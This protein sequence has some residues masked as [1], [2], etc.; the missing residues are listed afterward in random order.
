MKSLLKKLLNKDSNEVKG[1]V[2]SEELKP[3]DHHYKAYVGPPAQYDFMGATQFRLLTTLGLREEH[4]VLDVGCGSLRAGRLLIP[5]LQKG[6]YYGIEPNQWLVEEGIAENL[7]RDALNIKAPNFYHFD[8]FSLSTAGSAFDFI[9]AQS[10]FSHCGQDLIV[11]CLQEVKKVLNQEGLFLATFLL[12]DQNPQQEEGDFSGGGW[13]YP[14]CVSFTE[15]KIHDLVNAEGF[16]AIKLPWFHP[17]QTW[18]VI[19]LQG[20]NTIS[21]K[22]AQKLTGEVLRDSRF[23]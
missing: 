19:S 1:E 16:H 9:V 21:E 7:G 13:I 5:Y 12:P 15:R 10:I 23:I 6:N 17:R 11:K 8:D 14:G 3:G 4:K 18:F 20:Q 22:E 2:K